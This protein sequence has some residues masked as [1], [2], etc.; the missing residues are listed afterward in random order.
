MCTSHVHIKVNSNLFKLSGATHITPLFFLNF[1]SSN[2]QQQL[3]SYYIYNH[4]N[5]ASYKLYC[6]ESSIDLSYNHSL[7][8]NPIANILP[9]L[10][11]NPLP[12][13]IYKLRIFMWADCKRCCE[14]IHPQAPMKKQQP[15]LSLNLKHFS[16]LAP[17][18]QAHP[19]RPLQPQEN[20]LHH[21]SPQQPF[22]AVFSFQP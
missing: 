21:I 11:R 4:N 5:S 10:F 17:N 1:H 3:N 15:P 9:I 13:C 20:H 2:C 8:L 6:F 22:Y 12:Y 16:H 14:I 7:F 18:P 19:P